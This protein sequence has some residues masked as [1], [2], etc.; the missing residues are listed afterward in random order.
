[1]RYKPKN[2]AALHIALAGLPDKMRV[3][4]DPDIGVS[5][6][7]RC[8]TSECDGVAREFCDRDPAGTL[9]RKCSQSQQGYPCDARLAKTVKHRF[10]ILAGSPARAILAYRRG[11][12]N[13]EEV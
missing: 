9:S 2:V 7:D 5:A 12:G 13:Q 4:V 3:E 8:R 6:K 1:M 11:C 10:G